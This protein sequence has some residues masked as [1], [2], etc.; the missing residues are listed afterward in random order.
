MS[1]YKV[2]TLWSGAAGGPGVT[3]MYFGTGGGTA[4]NAVAAVA[5]FWNQ[6][7]N[8]IDNAWNYATD[9]VVLTIDETT[10]EPTGADGVTPVSSAGTDSNDHL[11]SMTQGLI[12]L[13]TGVYVSGRE[14]RGR[15][16]IPGPTEDVNVA[17]KPKSDYKAAWLDAVEDQLINGLDVDFRVYSRAHGSASPVIS[18]SVWDE[19]AALRTRRS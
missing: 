2:R 16:F 11:P 17:G 5:A 10:G 8:T 14:L 13:R 1:L 12:Q 3:T 18:A 9:S 7:K 4:A 6:A 19:W 15:I